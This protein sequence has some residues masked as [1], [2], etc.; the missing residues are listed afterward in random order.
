MTIRCHAVLVVLLGCG[1]SAAPPSPDASFEA[2]PLT[3]ARDI[4][5]I[6]DRYCVQCHALGAGNPHGEPHFTRDASGRSVG[7]LSDCM[8][9]GQRVPLVLAGRPESSFLMYKLGAATTLVISGT[10]CE[11]RMPLAADAPLAQTDPD[12]VDQIRR[13]IA[14]G[15]R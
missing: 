9:A 12:A 7:T 1:E 4:Q 2:A 10:S 6:L 14:E 13:W 5:P 3:L 8:H 15:A 11:Q